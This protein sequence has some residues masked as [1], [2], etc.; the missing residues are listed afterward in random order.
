MK[1]I[2][3]WAVTI[4]IFAFL[5]NKYPVGRV[6]ETI[7]SA[8]WGLFL[9]LM[10]PY[11]IFY[12]LVDSFVLQQAVSWFNARVRYR[13][14]LPV[15]ATAYIL[16]LVNT[17]VGQGGVAVYLNRRYGIPF[18][19]VTGTV[20]FIVL[21]E[22]YQLAFYSAVGAA[23]SGEA[24]RGLWPV[25]GGLAAYLAAHLWF[26]SRPRGERLANV[27]FLAAF[28]KATPVQYLLLLLYKTPNLLAAVVVHWLALPLF[29]IDIPFLKLL[30]FLPLVFFAAAFPLAA[31]HLGPSQAAW[32]YFFADGDGTRGAQL[33]AY[34][35]AAHFMFMLDNALIGLVFLRRATRELGPEADAAAAPAPT[36]GG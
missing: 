27:A 15:R 18:W 4:A 10:V 12:T 9:A 1:R 8:R 26:F 25:Y 5:F 7:G 21:I 3:P 2:A 33:V 13:D 36:A 30:T 11:S 6:V 20:V 35:L 23:V 19:Q 24:P 29:G 22:M 34:S 32:V 17:F 31:A 28:W 14:I 16:S